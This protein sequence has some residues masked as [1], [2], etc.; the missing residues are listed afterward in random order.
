VTKMDISKIHIGDRVRNDMGNLDALAASIKQHG[1]IH[2]PAVTSGGLLIA[3][4]RRIL[5]CARLGMSSIPVRII[6]VEDLLSAERDENQ[7]RKGFTPSEAVAIA[8][9]IESQLQA[10][11]KVRRSDAAKARWARQKGE[12]VI[13]VDPTSIIRPNLSISAGAIVGMGR[14]RYEKAKKVVEAAERETDRF[15][16]IVERM[17]ATGNVEGAAKELRARLENRPIRH[18]V[19]RNM[20][21]R[22]PNSEIE[23]AITLLA[24]LTIGIGRINTQGLDASRAKDWA[25]ELKGHVSIINRFI[26]SLST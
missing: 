21:H 16:D 3:G 26:R 25:A 20:K 8:R 2:P 13:E 22:D 23:R 11:S 19:L 5:A 1:L 17:D 9:A 12:K 7:E 18:A 14:W 15:G 6:D 4:Q 24:G 10:A